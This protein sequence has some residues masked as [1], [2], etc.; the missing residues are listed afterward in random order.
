MMI[1]VVSGEDIGQVSM[2]VPVKFGDSS[3]NVSGD[4]RQCNC[5]RRHFLMVF[6]LR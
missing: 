2:D 6:E 5:R 4:I 3:I 1:C